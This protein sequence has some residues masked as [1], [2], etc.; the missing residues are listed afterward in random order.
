MKNIRFVLIISFVCSL[1]SAISAFAQT[2]DLSLKLSRDFGYGGFNNDIQGLFSMKVTGPMDLV[3]VIFYIDSVAIG[4]DIQPP[5]IL[6]FNTDSYSIGNHTL[7][8]VG[9]SQNGQEYKS[10]TISANF[11]PA[12]VGNSAAVKIVVPVLIIVF[13]AIILSFVIPLITGRGKTKDVPLGAE[14]SYITGGGIC[15]RCHR[16]FA[17]PLFSI[18]LGLSKLARCPYCGRWSVVRIQPILKLREAERAELEWDKGK[19]AEETD[20]E[21]LRKTIEDSKYQ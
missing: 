1:I 15:P 19:V 5:F 14:R 12:A 11:V 13:G 18:N 9:Y 7:F 3:K 17:L 2:N 8:A 21:K 20:E 16:P 6:Q 10:N 4:E